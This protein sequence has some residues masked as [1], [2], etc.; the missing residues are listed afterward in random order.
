MT[1]LSPLE[2]DILSTFQTSIHGCIRENLTKYNGP[3]HQLC[4]KVVDDHKEELMT[5][6]EQGFSAVIH[7]DEFKEAVHLAFQ[8]KLAKLLVSKLEGTVEKCVDTL[9]SNPVLR[10]K[11][12]LAIESIVKVENPSS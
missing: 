6:V 7:A 3:L 9:R 11:M 8:H 2:S 4:T 12:T 5:I 10:A 1:K